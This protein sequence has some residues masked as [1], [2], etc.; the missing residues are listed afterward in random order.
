MATPAGVLMGEAWSRGDLPL[1]EALVS[2]DR[3]QYDQ[4]HSDPVEGLAGLEAK[5]AS[6]RREMPCLPKTVED[7]VRREGTDTWTA[8]D[9]RQ[10]IGPLPESPT[11]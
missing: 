4:L 3:V 5:V 6:A 9:L 8:L 1:V 10:Q 11:N 7:G 2:E